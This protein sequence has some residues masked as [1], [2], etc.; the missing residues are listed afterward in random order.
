MSSKTV[1]RAELYE[2]VWTTP[3]SRLA[4]DYGV[5]DVALAKTCKRM[6]IP[7]PGRGYWAR[8]AAGAKPKRPPLPPRQRGQDEAVT[9]RFVENL[10]V[11]PPRP[12][13]PE[14]KVPRD[15]RRAHEAI[16]QLASVL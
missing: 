1:T 4:M 14:V 7:R 11:P 5:S 9:L 16:Q 2:Q 15:L 13:P 8:L 3:M 10:I 12:K 6:N